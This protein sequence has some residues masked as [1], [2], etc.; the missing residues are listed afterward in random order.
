MPGM[1]SRGP[2]GASVLSSFRRSVK[3][4]SN[5]RITMATR[6]VLANG[7]A[8][9]P[10]A[11]FGPQRK[12]LAKTTSDPSSN[13]RADQ[14]GNHASRKYLGQIIDRSLR[15]VTGVISPLFGDGIRRKICPWFCMVLLPLTQETA[16]AF[17]H[18]PDKQEQ[19]KQWIWIG[20]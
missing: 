1:P 11:N 6:H 16:L 2:A 15:H 7:N 20:C 4:Y 14:S 12:N 9:P 3:L 10:S 13:Q 18:K 8:R 19:A 5:C 17:S